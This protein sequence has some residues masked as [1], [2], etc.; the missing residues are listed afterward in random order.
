MKFKKM[1]SLVLCSGILVSSSLGL[2]SSNTSDIGTEFSS[3]KNQEMGITPMA[4]MSKKVEVV[5]YYK[6]KSSVPTS[7]YYSESYNGKLTWRGNINLIRISYI[8]PGKYSAV[9]SGYVYYNS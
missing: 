7:Y 2:A 8:S 6:N 3:S 9:Y 5:K 4:V 1:F